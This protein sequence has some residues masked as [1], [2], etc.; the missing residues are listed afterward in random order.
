MR[1]NHGGWG[2]E[3]LGG[4]GRIELL[5]LPDVQEADRGPV[6]VQPCSSTPALIVSSM[7]SRVFTSIT[8]DSMPRWCSKW[9]SIRPGR[10]NNSNLGTHGF[11]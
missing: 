5:A 1:D 11:S 4:N 6:A 7:S 10:A 2:R 9:D 8:T 3:V